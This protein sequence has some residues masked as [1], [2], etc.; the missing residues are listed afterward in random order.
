MLVLLG[1]LFPFIKYSQRKHG[2]SWRTAH[3]A[4]LS[5]GRNVCPAVSLLL[6]PQEHCCFST[7]G[8]SVGWMA[9]S[10][11]PA[12]ETEAPALLWWFYLLCSLWQI[13]RVRPC[14][15]H[16]LSTNTKSNK[17]RREVWALAIIKWMMYCMF[18]F[19]EGKMG[20]EYNLLIWV[21]QLDSLFFWLYFLIGTL[22]SP[23]HFLQG[24]EISLPLLFYSFKAHNISTSLCPAAVVCLEEYKPDVVISIIYLPAQLCL[25]WMKPVLLSKKLNKSYLFRHVDSKYSLIQHHLQERRD[26]PTSFHCVSSFVTDTP[27]CGTCK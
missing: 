19:W 7:F 11:W 10:P 4:E 22:L 26:L 1:L 6:L 24:K 9:G 12:A 15:W 23:N 8:R 13:A 25:C 17:M 27:V 16:W 14:L 5:C 20:C 21:R 18:A 2:C 3:R